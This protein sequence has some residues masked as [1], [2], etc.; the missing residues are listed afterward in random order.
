MTKGQELKSQLEDIWNDKEV[1]NIFHITKWLHHS[2][3]KCTFGKREN[4]FLGL[5]QTRGRI[6]SDAKTFRNWL[7]R[8][9][10]QYTK[11]IAQ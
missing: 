1:R 2:D 5:Y 8:I 6:V 10:R 3:P 7:K 9:R 4:V 11:R